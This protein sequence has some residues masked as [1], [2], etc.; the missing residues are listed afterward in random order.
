MTEISERDPSTIRRPRVDV[1]INNFNYATYLASA[2]DS[3][4]SQSYPA[5]RV[6]VVDDGSTDDSVEIIRSYGERITAVV[7]DNGGQAS[8]MNAGMSAVDGDVVIFLDADDMLEPEAAARIAGEFSTHPDLARVHYRLRVMDAGGRLTD[9]VKPEAR[10]P[11]AHG[12]LTRATLRTPFDGAWLPT[13]GN[14]FSVRS[15]RRIL[16]VPE[17]DYRLCADWYLVHVSSV[18]GPV[19]AIDEPL[20]RYRMHGANGFSRAGASLDLTH[21]AETVEYARLT[22]G[23]IHRIARATGIP[24]DERRTA[25]MCDI[26]NRAVLMRADAGVQGDSRLSLFRGGLRAAGGRRDVGVAMKGMFVA[27][28]AAALV[29]PRRV[30]RWL[31]EIFLLPERRQVINSVLGALHRS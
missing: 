2:I 22:R 9:E 12:D 24:H 13:S 18:V 17:G 31:S 26:A 23:H 27:W 20:A 3:A 29:S 28:L 21:L 10:L 4:L 30:S 19:G 15:L 1:I 6:I 14:A 8:A 16:P 11:L 25:S 7:K 5:T